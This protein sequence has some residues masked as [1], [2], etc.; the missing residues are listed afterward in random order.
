MRLIGITGGVGAGK[1]T[2]LEY[3]KAHYRCRVYLADQVA[4]AVKE[5][6]Q[7]CYEALVELLGREVLEENGQIHKGRMAERI[8]RDENLLEQ[9]NALVHP[10]VRAYLLEKIREAR[11]E[12]WAELFFIEAALLI[13]CGY[14]DIVDEMWYVHAGE[15]LRSGRLRESRGY[16]PE[17]IGQIMGSQLTEEGFRA[18][19]DFVIDNS[20]TPEESYRQI[21]RRLEGYTWRQ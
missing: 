18:G 20:G 7:P 15:D 13:E 4:H 21:R 14:R 1:S 5:P 19:S 9:V 11:E 8:F 3:I 17:K 2:I 16:S 6:G 12:G 10:A